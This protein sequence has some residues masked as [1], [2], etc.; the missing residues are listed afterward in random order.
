MSM[1]ETWFHGIHPSD[2]EDL[3][4]TIRHQEANTSL[5]KACCRVGIMPRLLIRLTNFIAQAIQPLSRL[6]FYRCGATES[7]RGQGPK[8]DGP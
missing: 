5:R 7:P 3:S 1:E 4:V 6:F 8:G 2:E